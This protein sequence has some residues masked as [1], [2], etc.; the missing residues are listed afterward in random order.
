M[1]T[2][3]KGSAQESNLDPIRP[4]RKKIVHEWSLVRL[5]SKKRYLSLTKARASETFL[6]RGSFPFSYPASNAFIRDKHYPRCVASAGTEGVGGKTWNRTNRRHEI[7]PCLNWRIEVAKHR[8]KEREAQKKAEK[9]TSVGEGGLCNE[10]GIQQACN[11]L[12]GLRCIRS[13]LVRPTRL[14]FPILIH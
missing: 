14:I 6:L 11:Q 5:S 3:D 13:P 9:T 4:Y 2:P 1:F 10:P 8:K 7:R 12:L